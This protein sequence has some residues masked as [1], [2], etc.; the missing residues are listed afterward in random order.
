[1]KRKQGTLSYFIC[2]ESHACQR[3]V[4]RIMNIYMYSKNNPSGKEY[5]TVHIQQFHSTEQTHFFF[6]LSSIVHL[7]VRHFYVIRKS[8]PDIH[9]SLNLVG[10][11][12]VS[13]FFFNENQFERGLGKFSEIEEKDTKFYYRMWFDTWVEK[14]TQI[15]RKEK[16][17]I[18][19]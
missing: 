17:Q 13:F 14:S 8:R 3:R 9:S 12:A 11:Q 5:C 6:P 18:Q 16:N 7:T 1:M 10:F 2:R 19:T 15:Q 4:S